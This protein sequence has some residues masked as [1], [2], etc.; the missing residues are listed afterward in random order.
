MRSNPKRAFSLIETTLSTLMVGVLFV[1]SMQT[2]AWSK[3]TTMVN[4]REDIAQ[5]IAQDLLDEVLMQDYQEK[6]LYSNGSNLT[7]RGR[8]YFRSVNDYAGYTETQI[9][10]KAGN[11]RPEL[12]GWTRKVIVRYIDPED[13]SNCSDDKGIRRVKIF[14][15]FNGTK[16]YKLSGYANNNE[17]PFG[18]SD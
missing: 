7:A 15:Y 8:P 2:V 4:M 1:A 5:N 6:T 10:D 16:V 14:V 3:K 11:A 13:G 12:A 18:F 9:Q 17:T